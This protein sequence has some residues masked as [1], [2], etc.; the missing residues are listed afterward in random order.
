MRFFPILSLSLA[1]LVSAQQSPL[2]ATPSDIETS[3][4]QPLFNTKDF[5]VLKHEDH[6]LHTI[7]MKMH[8]PADAVCDGATKGYSGYLSIG[9]WK[10]FYF[11]YFESRKD[12]V[13]DPLS[14]FYF[15]LYRS[16]LLVLR[17]G[18]GFEDGNVTRVVRKSFR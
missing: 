18:I 8:D 13:T 2:S 3:N 12:A 16:I 5:T 6:P 15:I 9:D 1:A 7:S 14:E 4:E 10:H 17:C 11:Y